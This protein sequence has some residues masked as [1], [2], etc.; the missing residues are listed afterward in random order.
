MKEIYFKCPSCRRNCVVDASAAGF[1]APCPHCQAQVRIPAKSGLPPQYLRIGRTVAMNAAIILVLTAIGILL[2]RP[3]APASAATAQT[4]AA[5]TPVAT[6]PVENKIIMEIPPELVSENEKLAS[7]NRDIRMKWEELGNWVLRNV[8]GKYP[9]P[10]RLVSN[11]KL[12]PVN[13][14]FT[15][16]ADLAD[17]LQ[18]NPQEKSYVD[19]ALMATHQSISELENAMMTVTQS[20]PGKVMLYIPPFVEKGTAVR[21]DLYSA[22]ETTLGRSRFDRFVDV[23]QDELEKNYHYFGTASRTMI[24]EVTYPEDARLPPYL[25]IKDGWVLPQGP[26]ARAYNVTESAVNELPK[27]YLAYLNFLPDDVAAYAR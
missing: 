19:D 2:F 6:A 9:L 10:E 23:S 14:D 4:S 8:R 22:L 3:K 1:L 15:L 17:L 25:V 11:L 12:S 20:T 5:E 7:E 24:F 26:S 18:V 21:D 16:Q 27:A 13:D